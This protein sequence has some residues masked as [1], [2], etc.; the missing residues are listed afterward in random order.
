MVFTWFAVA[1]VIS[2]TL[3]GYV[4]YK[5]KKDLH[6]W[7]LFS[8]GLLLGVAFFH[9]LPEAIERGIDHVSFDQLFFS[10][11]LVIFAL[12]VLDSLLGFHGHHAHSEEPHAHGDCDHHDED[13]HV[14]L[15]GFVRASG[16]VSHSFMDGLAI[17]GGFAVE[18]KLGLIITT[19][20]L[21][22]DFAD[23]MS[24][25]SVMRQVFKGRTLGVRIALV[26]DA[27][28]PVIGFFVGQ[29]IAP[30][31]GSLAIM[32]AGFSGLFVYLSLVEL[33]PQAHA[34]GKA[35]K[36]GWMLVAL[37]IALTYVVKFAE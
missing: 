26:C 31:A 27:L 28:A 36:Y 25:V 5:W 14:A 20:V 1:P 23:G 15:R 13:R 7:L 3:G 10:P 34:N 37:G 18:P 16:L 33:L 8:G 22:H 35:G 30:G 11:L 4:V 19:A 17:G 21:L 24:M 29:W 6:P 2:T 9:L 12:Y 32:L